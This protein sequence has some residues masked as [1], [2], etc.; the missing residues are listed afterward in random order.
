MLDP[1][2]VHRSDKNRQGIDSQKKDGICA[3]LIK[4]DFSGAKIEIIN[5]K[6]P[7]IVSQRG[8]IAKETKSA[9]IVITENNTSKM[10]LK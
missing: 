4:A 8:I 3:K 6:N 5:S 9:L 2:M 1:E 7:Q 10:F